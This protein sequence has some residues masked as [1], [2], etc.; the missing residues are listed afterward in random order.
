MNLLVDSHA[1]LWLMQAN[2]AISADAARLLADPANRLHLS[3]ASIWEIGIKAGLGRITLAVP[4]AK[5]LATAIEGYGLVVVPITAEDCIHYEGLRFP[6]PRHRD[7][8]DRM[9][10]V[11]AQR[12]SLAVVSV[13]EKLDR[14]GIVRLW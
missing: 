12:S 6:D 7:P 5:F 3:M 13:D 8:F 4:Y 9:I 10:V 2:P 11:H 1:L 14:Y